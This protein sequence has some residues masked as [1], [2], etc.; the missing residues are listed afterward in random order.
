LVEEAVKTFGVPL[1]NQIPGFIDQYMATLPERLDKSPQLVDDITK[2][3]IAS[4]MK[5][6]NGG[7]AVAPG[8]VADPLSMI[9]K[10]WRGLASMAMSF[11]GGNN[12]G[13][14]AG[15]VKEAARSVFK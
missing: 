9:P 11:M 7:Q 12:G 10:K 13:A 6:F 2:P 3:F 15:V 4:V 8:D 1:I 5:Q 14:A